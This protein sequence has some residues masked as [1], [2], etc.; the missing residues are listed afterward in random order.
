MKYDAIIVGA[1]PSG[2]FLA[3]ELIKKAPQSKILL[4]DRGLD[5][6][7]RHCPVLQHKLDRCPVSAKGYRE[8][9][10]ACSMTSGFG[11]SGAYSD[12][13]FNITTA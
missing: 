4:I 10:P 2:Y 12:G 5:I 11:G 7:K 9:H 1:G 13:K 6:R 8:C 3:Y